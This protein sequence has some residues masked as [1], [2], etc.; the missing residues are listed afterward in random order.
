M[1]LRAGTMALGH[2]DKNREALL[3][4]D[5]PL[6]KGSVQAGQWSFRAAHRQQH[7]QKASLDHIR[8]TSVEATGK[9]YNHTAS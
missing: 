2:A 1:P 5:K 4:P 8:V 6:E 7:F 3:W 9:R